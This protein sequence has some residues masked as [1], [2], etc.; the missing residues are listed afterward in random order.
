[1]PEGSGSHPISGD[2]VAW[3]AFLVITLFI[4][5]LA[6]FLR[7]HIA[8]KREDR[9]AKTE[10][11]YNLK[12]TEAYRRAVGTV[13]EFPLSHY[14]LSLFVLTVV[15]G[16][17]AYLLVFGA[18]LNLEEPNFVL[19][20]GR[21]GDLTTVD[22]N[23]YQKKTLM[24]IVMAFL[25]AYVW[26]VQMTFRRILTLDLTPG[27]FQ[28][29]SVRVLVAIMVATVIRHVYRITG[30]ELDHAVLVI[31]GFG[32]GVFPQMAIGYLKEGVKKLLRGGTQE[33]GALP[34]T[35][36]E[37]I[38]VF[39]RARLAEL[40][41]EDAQNL[42]HANPVGV[43]IRTP[44]RLALVTDWIA[45]AQALVL[46]N[47]AN[48]TKLREKFLIRTIFQLHDSLSS[49]DSLGEI[50]GELEVPRPVLENL[51]VTLEKQ[52][53]FVRLVELRDQMVAAP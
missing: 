24:V 26:S 50:G 39:D 3:V 11:H 18:T 4:P 42:A 30:G 21:I 35:M 40:G 29:I 43:F 53:G 14:L 31:L 32:C 22:L 49:D 1:M 5:A 16:W 45:Q 8:Q 17:N 9:L 28:S 52:P 47:C 48:F 41:I 2:V 12:T 51:R 19:A 10:Q 20:G 34:L 25:G 15:V 38:S 46:L 13:P 33:A 7:T 6:I 37:G 23:E 36:I 44:Y 27:T